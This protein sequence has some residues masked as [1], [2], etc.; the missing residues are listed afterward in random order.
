MREI[1]SV[2]G[3]LRYWSPELELLYQVKEIIDDFVV[4]QHYSPAC[5]LLNQAR[6]MHDMFERGFLFV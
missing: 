1:L 3:G 4:L 5:V 2:F 6:E